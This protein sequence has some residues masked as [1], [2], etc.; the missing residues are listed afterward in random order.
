MRNCDSKGPLVVYISKMVPAEGNRFIAFGRVFSGTAYTGQKIRILGSDFKHGTKEGVHEKS[1][2]RTA[3]MMGRN[4]ENVPSVPCGNTIGLG[5]LDNFIQ[6][7]ATITDHPAAYPIRSMKYSVS[8]VVRVAVSPK[9][10][11]DLPK[12]VQGLQKLSNSDPL[13][14]CTKEETGELIVAGCGE[15]H[16]EICLKDLEELYAACP[17]NK[18]NPVVSYKETVTSE[19][20]EQ[21]LVKTQN[22]LNRMYAS[23]EPISEDLQKALEKSEITM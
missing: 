16:V 7:T 14:L 8:P 3:L 10:A 1:I 20:S 12:L 18:S 6:K 11:A 21:C 22:K 13:V 17:L 9:N 15:L 4:I 5:W 2:Q 19:S 23:C